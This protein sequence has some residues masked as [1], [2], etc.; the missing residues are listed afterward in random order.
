LASWI[1]L[2][3]FK[4]HVKE[5]NIAYLDKFSAYCN[6]PTPC[7]LKTNNAESANIIPFIDSITYTNKKDPF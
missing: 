4:I 7:R 2:F 6:P 5:N 3:S 1:V